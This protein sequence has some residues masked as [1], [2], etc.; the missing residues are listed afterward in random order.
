M[1]Y[2]TEQDI[3]YFKMSFYGLENFTTM[4]SLSS[5]TDR[6]YRLSVFNVMN[7]PR[8]PPPSEVSSYLI[9]SGYNIFKLQILVWLA[10][11]D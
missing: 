8:S 4:F 10:K 11:L 2:A 5:V 3:S 1:V 9:C 6:M 7:K